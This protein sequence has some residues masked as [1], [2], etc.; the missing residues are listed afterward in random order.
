MFC[1]NCGTKL[2]DGAKFCFECGAKLPTPSIVS[3]PTE[4]TAFTSDRQ[5]ADIPIEFTIKGH[6]LKF[7]SSYKEY[8]EK[9]TAFFD[10]FIAGFEKR[11]TEFRRTFKGIEDCDQKVIEITNFGQSEINQCIKQGHKFLLSSEIY[12]ISQDN[13]I[14]HIRASLENGCYEKRLGE[15]EEGYLRIVATDEQWKE[16]R[17]MKKASRGHWEGGGFG[18][19]GAIKGA[20]TAG[21]MN[22]VGN[23]WHGIG[24]LISS[25]IDNHFIKKQKK[26][27]LDSKDWIQIFFAGI[28]DDINAIFEE[29]YRIYS[30]EKNVP[31]PPVNVAQRVTL[32]E[33]AKVVRDNLEEFL[34]LYVMALQAYPYGRGDYWQI[35]KDTELVNPEVLQMLEFF[36]PKTFVEHT[37]I[38]MH[39]VVSEQL[40]TGAEN[41]YETLDKKIAYF[42]AFAVAVKAGAANSRTCAMYV[43]RFLSKDTETYNQLCTQRLTADDGEVFVSKEELQQYLL[44]REKFQAYMEKASATQAISDKLSLLEQVQTEVCSL[45]VISQFETEKDKLLLCVNSP[46]SI[47][48]AQQL[49][50]TDRYQNGIDI[51]MIL[52]ENGISDAQYQLGLLY[53]Q[54]LEGKVEQNDSKAYRYFESASEKGHDLA[55]CCAGEMCDTY[56]PFLNYKKAIEFYTLAA[57]QGN[58]SAQMNLA[59]LYKEGVGTPQD[60]EK[61]RELYA[62]AQGREFTVPSYKLNSLNELHSKVEG[63][64]SQD[65]LPQ[66]IELLES[67][68]EGI[69]SAVFYFLV[70]SEK[71]KEKIKKAVAAYA[72]VTSDEEIL[73]MCDSTLLGSAKEGYVLTNKNIYINR[74]KKKSVVPISEITGVNYCIESA[75]GYAVSAI[76][77][78]GEYQFEFC[79]S[80][81]SSKITQGYFAD[82]FE[83]IKRHNRAKE[84]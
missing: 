68:Y 81:N 56:G 44:D 58:A 19:S 46:E 9:R 41:S 82:V 22:A 59:Y 20:V 54:G 33:N 42:D 23:A 15:F 5:K 51:L 17:Q 24:D 1:I 16:Y 80:E 39:R 32:L 84:Q 7:D 73:L 40:T 74:Q 65:P 37:A 67:Q 12:G 53:Y 36:L 21:A 69:K 79:L 47:S 28:V 63:I 76:T 48:K 70:G 3:E 27:Y 50:E 78:N 64:N 26:E 45:R 18:V 29:V 71:F 10:E 60:Q 4:N 2:P 61:A 31:M 72:S 62:K 34:K 77:C 55:Q 13:L 43:D 38:T 8:T 83:L 57:E 30:K 6:K 11:A 14:Q 66:Q 49:L 25:G 52:A 75:F 35:L